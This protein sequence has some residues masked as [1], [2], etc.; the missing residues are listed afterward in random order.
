MTATLT[1]TATRAGPVGPVVAHLGL[2]RA[3]VVGLAVL[4]FILLDR[5]T[6]LNVLGRKP[7]PRP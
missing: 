3:A 4:G 1:A 7:D 5:S 6:G 2:L